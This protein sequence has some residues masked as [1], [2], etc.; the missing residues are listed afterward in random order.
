MKLTMTLQLLYTE[1]ASLCHEVPLG[2]FLGI[3]RE[4]NT[5]KPFSVANHCLIL[6][7]GDA[8]KQ[9][10]INSSGSWLWTTPY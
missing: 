7:A 9:E 8:A 1:P 3:L 4:S 5:P 2:E 6:F 10:P